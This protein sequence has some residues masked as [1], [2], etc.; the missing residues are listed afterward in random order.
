MKDLH[1]LYCWVDNNFIISYNMPISHVLKIIS[2]IKIVSVSHRSHHFYGKTHQAQHLQLRGNFPTKTATASHAE[3]V[4][5]NQLP[6]DWW[7]KWNNL[8]RICTFKLRI[9]HHL[10]KISTELL[11]HY[12]C[13]SAVNCNWRTVLTKWFSTTASKD[14]T[15]QPWRLPRTAISFPL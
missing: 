13:K 2:K 11:D 5:I 12:H 4:A 9:K 10:K 7:Q 1:R 8:E 3:K 15:I 6:A 14:G